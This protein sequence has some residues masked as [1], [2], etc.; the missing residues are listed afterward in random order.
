RDDLICTCQSTM[1]P[2]LRLEVCHVAPE[3]KDLSCIWQ[4]VTG[5]LVEQRGLPGS[6]RTDE[7]AS[8]ARSYAK[9]D[10]LC[11]GKATVGLAKIHHLEGVAG[12]G[13]PPRRRA[14]MSRKPGTSPAGITITMNRKTNPSSMFQRST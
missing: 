5:D 12:H 6:V 9:A 4:D 2:A 8:F 1:C 14:I 13:L 10:I 11:H 3:Q 7:Q